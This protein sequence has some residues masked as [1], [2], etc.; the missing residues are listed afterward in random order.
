MTPPL[1]RKSPHRKNNNSKSTKTEKNLGRVKMIGEFV[2][3]MEN[4]K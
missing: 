3:F 1:K 2:N 4:M